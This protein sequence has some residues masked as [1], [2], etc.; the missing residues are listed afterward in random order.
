MPHGIWLPVVVD[1]TSPAGSAPLERDRPVVVHAPSRSRLKG[2]ADIDATLRRLHDEGLCEYRRLERVPPTEMPAALAA[3]DVVLDQFAIG[4]YGVLA[5]EA[6]AAGRVVVGH[7]RQDV[8]ERVGE[9]LPVVEATPD[10]VEDVLR[11]LVD[12]RDAA[13]ATAAAGRAFVERVHGGRRSGQVLAEH[14]LSLPHRG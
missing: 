5:C 2:S 7:V 4:S 11:A 13:R 8:R 3:A 9:P 12:D 10:D 14:L 6:M 1:V